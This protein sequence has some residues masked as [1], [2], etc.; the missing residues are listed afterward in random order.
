MV[1]AAVVALAP[2]TGGAGAAG[3]PWALIE[4]GRAQ[5][6]AGALRAAI[7]DFAAARDAAMGAAPHDLEALRAL[8]TATMLQGRA[9]IDT[10]GIDAGIALQIEAQGLFTRL[11]ERRPGDADVA[12]NLLASHSWL[13][14]AW[15]SK[16]DLTAA[17][18]HYRAAL[19]LADAAVAAAPSSA[20]AL[21]D[22]GVAHEKIGDVALAQ[23]DAVAAAAA[24]DRRRSLAL[25]VLALDP[26]DTERQ[27][28][29]GIAHI[30]VGDAERALGDPLT[31]RASYAAGLAIAA[32]LAAR[33]PAHLPLQGE[34]ALA[35]SRM[36]MTG[37]VSGP[38]LALLHE[39]L[40][41]RER[42]AAQDPQNLRWQHDLAM[43]HFKIGEAAQEH[44]NPEVAAQSYRAALVLNER[45]AVRDPA[46]RRS[47]V[48]DLVKLAE[49]DAAQSTPHL[50]RAQDLV[51][52]LTDP[53]DAWMAPEIAR[54]LAALP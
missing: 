27:R 39:A 5:V 40:A 19:A 29:L 1:L 44:G 34:H 37:S 43:A 21:E 47:V 16:G 18:A 6:S 42:L 9:E 53:A 36:A 26:E 48:I 15:R 3:N 49:V 17:E 52:T 11:A 8:G 45:L 31:T 38:D 41:I 32:R 30:L 33:F 10:G 50:R 24:Y 20:K 54:R 22:M 14:D 4:Q 2:E 7:A 12:Q 35:L 13:G 25:Q 51:R 23:G 28:K 46:R